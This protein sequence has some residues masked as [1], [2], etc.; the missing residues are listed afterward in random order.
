MYDLSHLR[1]RLGRFIGEL[2]WRA[3]MSEHDSFPIDPDQT[4][5]GNSRRNVQEN[6]DVFVMVVGARYGS[7]DAETNKSV[8]NLEFVEARARGVPTYVFARSDVLAQLEVWKQNRDAD[9]AAVVDTP[10]VFEFIDSF[11]GSGEVW[12]FGFSSAESIVDTL[13]HQ[14]AYLVQDALEI[15]QRARGHDHLL[16]ELGGDALMVALGRDAGWELRLFGT[17]LEAELGRRAPLRSEIERRLAQPDVTYI[18]PGDF[19]VWARDRLHEFGGYGPTAAAIVNDYVPQAFGEEGVPGDPL[20]IVAD[21]RRLAQVWEDIARWTLRC[22]SV[23]V[24]P[25]IQRLV[26]S[27]SDGSKNVLNEIWDFGHCV[28]PRLDE[29]IRGQQADGGPVVVQMTLTLT[30]DFDEF[31]EELARLGPRNV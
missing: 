23:R 9:Y 30:A 29:T 7:I 22:R 27:L 20:E 25:E 16:E 11:R 18:G 21:A 14:L 28:V 31:N 10:R 1:E 24:E 2:G 8:T 13:R 17:V 6:A 12:T 15:R 26:D 5:V 19:I 3:V 4:T